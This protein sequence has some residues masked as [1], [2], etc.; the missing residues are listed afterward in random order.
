MHIC[1][2]KHSLERLR[3]LQ[4]STWITNKLVSKLSVFH[5]PL[6]ERVSYRA[7]RQALEQT[8]YKTICT[9]KWPSPTCAISCSYTH[10][11]MIPCADILAYPLGPSDPVKSLCFEPRHLFHPEVVSSKKSV[12]SLFSLSLPLKTPWLKWKAMLIPFLF[13]TWRNLGRLMT[14]SVQLYLQHFT[15]SFLFS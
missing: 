5:D 1:V 8:H 6:C 7:H 10:F 2:S 14:P 13:L 12:P 15:V 9:V 3:V 11:L 4:V